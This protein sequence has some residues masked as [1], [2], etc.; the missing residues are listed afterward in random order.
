MMAVSPHID[1]TSQMLKIEINRG[2]A[3]KDASR[4]NNDIKL[5]AAQPNKALKERNESIHAVQIK[6]WSCNRISS[7]ATNVLELTFSSF[8]Q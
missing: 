7:D 6:K 1:K 4:L 8:Y 5:H 2:Q 3:Y